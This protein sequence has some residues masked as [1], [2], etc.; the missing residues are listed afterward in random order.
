MI[1]ILLLPLLSLF[2]LPCAAVIDV[3]AEIEKLNGNTS[4]Q[5]LDANGVVIGTLI[6]D[7]GTATVMNDKGYMFAINLEN[8]GLPGTLSVAGDFWSNTDCTG[9]LYVDALLVPKNYVFNSV[10]FGVLYIHPTETLLTN[11]SVGSVRL[12]TAG[13]A[14]CVAVPITLKYA[15]TPS[16]NV[17]ITTGVSFVNYTDA[18][19]VP[20]QFVK[21]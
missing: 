10:D 17:P 11:V 3:A 4:P 5:V 13:E 19:P 1:K 20:L 2:T 7:L 8:S 16:A 9:N 21:P 15:Y 14:G 6:G 18:Y 12:N